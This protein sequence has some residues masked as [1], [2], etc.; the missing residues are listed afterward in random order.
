MPPAPLPRDWA[1][2]MILYHF[3]ALLL[4]LG[5]L[6][7]AFFYARLARHPEMSPIAAF[8]VFTLAFTV[9]AAVIYNVAAL[10]VMLAGAADALKSIWVAVPLVIVVFAPAFWAATRLIQ[11]KPRKRAPSN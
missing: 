7:A 10:L 8:L 5:L 11:R 4:W 9:V 3:I 2:A 1:H 6:V